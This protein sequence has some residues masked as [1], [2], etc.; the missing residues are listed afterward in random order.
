LVSREACPKRRRQRLLSGPGARREGIRRSEKPCPLLAC[1]VTYAKP[2]TGL[3]ADGKERRTRIGRR[4]T[5]DGAER[6]RTVV[7]ESGRRDVASGRG[8]TPG[9]AFPVRGAGQRAGFRSGPRLER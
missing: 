2:G 1:E 8:C 4:R 5:A 9:R 7:L 3:S 6:R